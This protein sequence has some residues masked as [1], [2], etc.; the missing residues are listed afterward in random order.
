VGLAAQRG[1]M[2]VL[3]A[4]EFSGVVRDAFLALGHDAVS[5]DLLAT[6]RPG[7]HII[8]DAG[9][10]LAQG[11]DL[12]IAHPPCT[13][14]ASSG[15]RWWNGAG[16][17]ELQEQAVDFVR[18]LAD[19]A[20]P[21]IAVENPIGI[22][23]RVWR[24]G[25]ER[26]RQH[27]CGSRAWRRSHRARSSMAARQFVTASRRARSAGA[28]EAGRTRGSRLPWPRSGA[29]RAGMKGVRW[30]YEWGHHVARH[31]RSEIRAGRRE[32]PGGVPGLRSEYPVRGLPLRRSARAAP[33]Q[34]PGKAGR[35][36]PVCPIPGAV[37]RVRAG[38]DLTL[39]LQIW[40]VPSRA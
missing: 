21:R 1:G 12:M 34:V 9:A 36:D 28:S 19:C 32:R 10:L 33:A 2:R 15:A 27:A 31:Q 7:P 38:A 3:I 17:R 40:A 20:I 39:P 18:L 5:C 6:E 13:Y 30:A 22:L 8:G 14:L 23:S 35:R 29:C 11:W 16:R 4:C 25:M 24:K 37:T 26:L